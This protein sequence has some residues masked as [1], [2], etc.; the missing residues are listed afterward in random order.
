MLFTTLS[1][2]LDFYFTWGDG[3][4]MQKFLMPIILLLAAFTPVFGETEMT[5]VAL[6]DSTTAGTPAFR[7]PVED[8][9]NGSGNEQS[10]YAYWIMKRH[11][12]WQVLNR[13]VNGE[14]SDEILARFESD[15]LS[16]KPAVVIVLAGVND[17]YQGYPA[18][19][20][21]RNLKSI[22]DKA[23]EHNIKVM[24]CTIIP[25]NGATPQVRERKKEV[26]EWI[27]KY[28]SEHGLGF[29]DTN[30]AVEHLDHPGNLSGTPDGLHPDVEGYRKMGEA[31]TDALEKWPA[32]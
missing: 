32:L 20:V 6:G 30:R 15:V 29:C 23:S 5:I 31:V 24:A 11:P 8:P 28:S 12:E 4:K 16:F 3:S 13:G 10:Q 19:R 26:N 14:R 17:L 9:P 27:R 1:L 21:I 7:S 18:E 22:Y 2:I 25:Y